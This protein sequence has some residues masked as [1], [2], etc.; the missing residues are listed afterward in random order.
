V[1]KLN[2]LIH[3]AELD[4]QAQN[5]FTE[6]NVKETREILAP[7]EPDLKI[8]LD[9]VRVI[10]Q[11][12]VKIIKEMVNVPEH[13]KKV[14]FSVLHLLDDNFNRFE[15]NIA[16]TKLI[17]G[18]ISQIINKQ[19]D[20]IGYASVKKVSKLVK[21]EDESLFKNKNSDIV[22]KIF[23]WVIAVIEFKNAEK[24]SQP[25]KKKV[26]DYT[27][28]AND[29]QEKIDDYNQQKSTSMGIIEKKEKEI[30]TCI[31][32]IQG[33]ENEISMSKTRLENAYILM[34]LKQ[35]E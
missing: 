29:L 21:I 3:A 6:I 20:K 33:L 28:K 24:K 26:Q 4:L 34:K 27:Q 18:F 9:M 32:H 22:Y 23:K 14:I 11:N 15:W 16:S 25:Y 10:T 2:I 30:L 31:E 8:S 1:D 17:E 19:L 12:Q 13:Y 7:T 5:E 35:D